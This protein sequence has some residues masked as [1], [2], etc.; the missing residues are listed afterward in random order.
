MRI[1]EVAAMRFDLFSSGVLIGSV[2][3]GGPHHIYAYGPHGDAIGAFGD[4]DAAA[5][6]LLRRMQVAA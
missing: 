1:T 3:R 4:M 6:A 5:A 2:E